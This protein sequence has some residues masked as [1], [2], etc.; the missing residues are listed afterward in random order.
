MLK[1]EDRLAAVIY[2]ID[3]E[4]LI[5]P[6][7]AFIQTPTGEV[8]RNRLFDGL[9]ENE[10]AKFNNYLHFRN[11]KLLRDKPL[12]YR[13]NLDKAVDFLDAIDE[14]EP[15]GLWILKILDSRK[16]GLFYFILFITTGCWSLQF[17]RGSSLVLLRSLKWIGAVAFHVPE[18]R[19]LVVYTGEL[20]NQIK[21]YHLCYKY[22]DNKLSKKLNK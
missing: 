20:V 14:D 7:G 21:I 8:V 10:S 6:R 3:E 4:A 19:I 17:E 2:K 22:R 18:T 12:L 5:V 16:E 1:E 15:K 13:A 9:S 11:A